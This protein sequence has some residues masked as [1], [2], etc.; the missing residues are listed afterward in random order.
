M[1]TL[2]ADTGEITTEPVSEE[3]SVTEA[4]SEVG[5]TILR[6]EE[7]LRGKYEKHFLLSDGS[8]QATVY[9]EPI[10]YETATGWVEVDNTLSLQTAADGTGR[11]AT[12]DGLTDVSFA[13][14]TGDRLVTMSQGDY[15]LSWGVE[16]VTS[17]KKTISA[18]TAELAPVNP[19]DY[20]AEEQMT[21]ALK[22][23]ATLRY[24]NAFAQGAD[25]EYIVLP[26]RVKENIILNS[27]QDISAYMITVHVENLTAQLLENREIQFLNSA[28]EVVFTMTSP[29]MYDSAGEFSEDIEVEMISK[30]DTYYI[31]MNPD[32]NWL[33]DDNRV[34]PITID[35]QVTTSSDPQIIIDNYVMENSGVQNYTLD[36]LL[37]GRRNG[38]RT[39]TYIKFSTMPTIPSGSTITAAQ[40]TCWLTTGQSTGNTASAYMVTGGD[41]SSTAITWANMP[42]AATLLQSNI[43]HNSLTKYTF[44]CLTAV[45]RWYSGMPNGKNQNYGIMLRY[46]NE[47]INDYN[48]VYSADHTTASQRPSLTITYQ[49]PSNTVSV[50]EG[51][52]YTLNAQTVSGTI[53]WS[54][55]NTSIATV[56]ASGKVTGVKAGKLIKALIGKSGK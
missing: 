40:M 55:D 11:Y 26:S 35:P 37:I 2:A 41:W 48:P 28:N 43:S 27:K 10:H 34:Y 19:A 30:G 51:S 20:S 15:S 38:N 42:A 13:Q 1:P 33:A 4:T 29:Y 16:A 50:L 6:E 18:A 46:Y 47:S 14:S 9:N 39:R 25:L 8:Y 54:L 36:R 31:C 21:M 49:A 17:G 22:S 24:R 5:V 7:S 12:A 56:N 45:K 44:S 52:T 53:T 3:T 23:T 32:T